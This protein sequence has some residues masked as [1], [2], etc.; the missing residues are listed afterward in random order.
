MGDTWDIASWYPRTLFV[1]ESGRPPYDDY[2]K[3]N[4]I[5]PHQSFWTKE[6]LNKLYGSSSVPRTKCMDCA[7]CYKPS[8]DGE[9]VCLCSKNHGKPERET[10]NY[11]RKGSN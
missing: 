8:K 5:L 2:F 3:Y 1:N 11:K 4:V 6:Q 9:W 7:N 10:C